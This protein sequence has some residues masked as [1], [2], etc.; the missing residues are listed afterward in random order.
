M[1]NS[2]ESQD[3]F[4]IPSSLLR[5]AAVCPS[6]RGLYFRMLQNSVEEEGGGGGGGVVVESGI[7]GGFPS[8]IM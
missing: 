2:L 6:A 5:E 7:R 3:V 8:S 4:G 1:S